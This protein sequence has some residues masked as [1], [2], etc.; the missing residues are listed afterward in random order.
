MKITSNT[1]NLF[2]IIKELWWLYVI[3]GIAVSFAV[4]LFYDNLIRH[5]NAENI[6]VEILKKVGCDDLE[7][8]LII[9]DQYYNQKN[10]IF[11][12]SQKLYDLAYKKLVACELPT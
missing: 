11:K 3:L 12:P 7:K 6:L 9:V 2:K 4:I 8:N 1:T 10:I 5:T